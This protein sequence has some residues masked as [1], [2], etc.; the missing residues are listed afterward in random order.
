MEELARE[1]QRSDELKQK[2]AAAEKELKSSAVMNL[3]LE[4][5]QRSMKSLEEQLTTR[6][7]ELERVRKDGQLQH[8]AMM[9]LKKELG[10]H[11]LHVLCMIVIIPSH[12]HAC[13]CA[14]E[15]LIRLTKSTGNH[16]RDKKKLHNHVLM[17]EFCHFLLGFRC[18]PSY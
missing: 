14:C 17:Y 3:E 9:Q 6:S 2:L 16:L 4:D 15:Y 12:V 5:Y 1:R 10:S 18:T 11:V 13:T 8:D 7:S